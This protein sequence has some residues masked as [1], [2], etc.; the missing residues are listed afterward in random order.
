ML[1]TY[2]VQEDIPKLVLVEDRYISKFGGDT[3]PEKFFRKIINKPDIAVRLFADSAYY[4]YR[5]KRDRV[6]ILRLAVT[7]TGCYMEVFSDVLR[8]MFSIGRT[9]ITM[10]VP[11]GDYELHGVLKRRG[12]YPYDIE[13]LLKFRY[14]YSQIK[15]S[16][17]EDWWVLEE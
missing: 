15:S 5:V 2:A 6:H 17:L 1:P 16:E 14:N 3:L 9:V 13:G 8:T 11:P 7:N 12:W 10:N 4:I